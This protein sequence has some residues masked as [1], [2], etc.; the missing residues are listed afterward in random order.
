[1]SPF[2]PPIAA[3]QSS[4]PSRNIDPPETPQRPAPGQP[5]RT[6]RQQPLVPA[7]P[8][9][10]IYIASASID[11]HVCVSSLVDP[12]DVTLRNFARPVQAVALSPEYKSDRQYLSGGL[13]GELILTTGGQA[14]VRSNANTS[15]ASHAAQGWLG[16]IGLGGNSGKDNIL[17][18]GEGTI[19]TI[20]WSLSGKFVAWVN[21]HGIRIMRT[22][23]HLEGNDSDAAWKRIGFIEKPNRKIWEEMAGVWKARLEWVDDRQL[24]SD[25]DAIIRMNNSNATERPDATLPHLRSAGKKSQSTQKSRK[26]EKLV[27]GWGDAAW[28]VHVNP[29]GAGAGRDVGERSV[30]SAEIIHLCVP[31]FRIHI[32]ANSKA[33]AFGSM[34]AL[35]L[36]Y[37]SI[38]LL[39]FLSLRIE[40]AMTTTIPF[41]RILLRN[42]A[43]LGV[44]T[45]SRP[46]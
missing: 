20:K 14:G 9:N 17:H 1:M 41:P 11:G 27:I 26:L 13:A 6:P 4:S 29:G 23:L 33:T 35:F 12:K 42:A 36:A 40:L 25:E 3:L 15:H 19:S 39:Y 16:A 21:E 38:P 8:S 46:S 34:I 31:S 7:I 18:S 2:P 43:C 28:I 24:E 32:R 45:V 44:T 37:R 22:S 5:P 10:Q 30:G